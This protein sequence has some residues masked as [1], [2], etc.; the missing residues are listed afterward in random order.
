MRK[1]L[2]W[3]LAVFLTALGLYWLTLAPGLIGIVDTPKLQFIGA[4]L[5]VPHPP[6]YPLYVLLSYA[7]SHL[8][9]G[10]LAYRIN[11]MSA[12]FGAATVALVFLCGRRIGA[13]RIASGIGAVGLASG[14]LFWS[15]AVVA[16][17]YTL[18]TALL[19]ATL[20]SVLSWARTRSVTAYFTAVG[21]VALSV[22]HHT[23][24]LLL[25]PSFAAYV[26]CVDARF[27]L[28]PRRLVC[29]LRADR[30]QD[31]P[32]GGVCRDS[33]SELYGRV[34]SGLEPP[35][36]VVAVRVRSANLILGTYAICGHNTPAGV[37]LGWCRSGDR[38]RA[39]HAVPTPGVG[40]L[41]GAVGPDQRGVRAGL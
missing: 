37:L 24:M 20:V 27:A 19:A 22:G 3:A 18:H 39:L 9:F 23:T 8:P 28:L 21:C 7:F 6:G 15:T 12:V 41:A 4:I 5:G 40:S 10:S 2:P 29:S 17:V 32:R 35:L 30:A 34:G 33:D 26:L 1:E 16:E 13:G 38:R 25:G 36:A 31:R 11:F 14:P